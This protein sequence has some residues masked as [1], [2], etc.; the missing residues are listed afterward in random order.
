MYLTGEHSS[1]PLTDFG[2]VGDRFNL[3]MEKQQGINKKKQKLWQDRFSKQP[4]QPPHPQ[5]CMTGLV[6]AKKSLLSLSAL[7]LLSLF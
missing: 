6:S 1:L 5:E 7:F 3:Q 2:N 4:L